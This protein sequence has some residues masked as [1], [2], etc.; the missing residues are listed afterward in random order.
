MNTNMTGLDNFSKT[1]ASQCALYW[2]EAALALE[3]LTLNL[4]RQ[5]LSGNWNVLYIDYISFDKLNPFM[6]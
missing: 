5:L 4:V 6:L 1:F 3:G 2:M